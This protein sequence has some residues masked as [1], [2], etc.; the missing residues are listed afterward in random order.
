MIGRL[1]A[2]APMAARAGAA[3]N[4]HHAGALLLGEMR[5]QELF[6]GVNKI[7]KKESA[8]LLFQG[9]WP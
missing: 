1:P 5:E 7:P 6:C 4:V 3:P 8:T 9:V 2:A